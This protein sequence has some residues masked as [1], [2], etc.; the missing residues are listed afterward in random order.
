MTVVL[1]ASALLMLLNGEPGMAAVVEVLPRAV[2]GAVNVSEAVAKL[3]DGG[4]PGPDIQEAIEGLGLDIVPFDAEL[5][6][7]TGLLRPLTRFAGLSLGDRACLALGMRLHVPVLTAD[8][9]WAG[10]D[11]DVEVRLLR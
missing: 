9:S 10:L 4:M 2:I 3:A 5:A 8:R 1:D 11:L 6:L 7:A